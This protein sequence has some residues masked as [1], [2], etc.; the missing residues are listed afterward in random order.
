MANAGDRDA[1]RPG[2]SGARAAAHREVA[3]RTDQK[4]SADHSMAEGLR[5]GVGVAARRA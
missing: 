2:P 3:W 4:E 5:A 1:G